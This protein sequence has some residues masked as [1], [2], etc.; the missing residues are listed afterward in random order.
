MRKICKRSRLRP[1][2][3]K[4]PVQCDKDRRALVGGAVHETP[5]PLRLPHDLN[6]AQKVCVRRCLPGHRYADIDEPERLGEGLF[7]HKRVLGV[8]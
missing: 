8:G 3:R 4:D 7:P 1:A 6:E 5:P 2:E